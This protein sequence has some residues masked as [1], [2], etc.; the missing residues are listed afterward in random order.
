MSDISQDGQGNLELMKAMGSPNGSDPIPPT[1][2]LYFLDDPNPVQRVV[3]W[4]RSKT[5]RKGHRRRYAVDQNGNTLT[6]SHLAADC[7][8]GN[9]GNASS[10]WKDTE[11]Q[12]LVAKDNEGR[13]CL[14]GN[15]PS[16]SA[17]LKSLNSQQL[18]ED[19]VF[20]TENQSVLRTE[21]QRLQFLAL[22]APKRELFKQAC[23]K[24][25]EWSAAVEADAL[26]AARAHVEAEERRFLDQFGISRQQG[27]K[28][29]PK[30]REPYV[31]LK[32]ISVPDFDVQTTAD[33]VQTES[34]IPYEGKNGSVQNVP[35]LLGFSEEQREPSQRGNTNTNAVPSEGPEQKA[36][37]VVVP[38]PTFDD[39]KAIYPP[40]A[41]DEANARPVFEALTP[42]EKQ[43][44]LDGLKIH[45]TCELWARRPD[46]I[47]FCS[48]FLT[49]RY[50]SFAPIP[51]RQKLDTKAEK[52]GEKIKRSAA[53][54]D[55]F[56]KMTGGGS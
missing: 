18:T 42:L 8:K 17:A 54:L 22:P 29:P 53:L 49:K 46:L 50:Y 1:Q 24:F 4:V 14:C 31:Q 25:A 39:L 11:D 6:I 41:L 37:V 51:Y 32:L 10:A 30:E 9:L 20:C 3:A 43:R 52:E 21:K 7:F 19:E 27:K 16:R 45:L 2:Y 33:S 38:P 28:R 12:K 56:R 36:V 13:L 23:P 55:E 47:P 44:A 26:A 34:A 15:V 35:T 40:N 48:K 5:I